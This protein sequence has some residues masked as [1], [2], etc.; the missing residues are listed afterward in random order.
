M[1]VFAENSGEDVQILRRLGFG[2]CRLSLAWP[3]DKAFEG[4][5][6]L[7][8]KRI[9][10]SY[11]QILER[12]LKR[13]NIDAKA[14]EISG[15]VE[16]APAIGIAEAVCDLVSTG[17][18]L[19][20]NGLR[21]VLR[22][23]DSEAVLLRSSRSFSDDQEA[24]VEK[25]LTR[26]DGTLRAKAARYVMMNAPKDKLEQI[27]QLIPGMEKPTI[28]PLMLDDSKVAIHA[29]AKEDVFWETIEQLKALGASSI[30]VVPIEK[31][32]E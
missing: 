2:H 21:E 26:I 14:V 13:N 16:V 27:S 32:I 7:N 15:S 12:Y 11:P 20:S 31:M 23:L 1:T 22:L 28:M 10:T 25:L 4:V 9:A 29:V 3:K 6:S 24:L 17:A 8:N 18:T 30:L 19:Q 5:S